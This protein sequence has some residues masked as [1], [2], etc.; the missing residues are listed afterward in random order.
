MSVTKESGN[1]LSETIIEDDNTKAFKLALMKTFFHRTSF[2][3]EALVYFKLILQILGLLY[4]IRVAL[5][6]T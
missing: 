2:S 3:F 4:S 6:Q 1:E 5:L